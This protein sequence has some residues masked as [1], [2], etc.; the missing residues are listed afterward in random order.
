MNLNNILLWDIENISYK[1]LDEIEKKIDSQYD[2]KYIISKIQFNSVILKKLIEHNYIALSALKDADSSIINEIQKISNDGSITII[3]NDSD[4]V[5][6]IKK[7][8]KKH[9]KVKWIV[10]D[11]NKKRILMKSDLSFENL[12]FEILKNTKNISNNTKKLNNF[13]RYETNAEKA[14][15]GK[16][17]FFNSPKSKHSIK[18]QK[19]IEFY[20]NKIEKAEKRRD[21][22]KQI[23]E[24]KENK[25][26][27]ISSCEV[28]ECPNNEKKNIGKLKKAFYVNICENCFDFYK[29]KNSEKKRTAIKFQKWKEKN[30]DKIKLLK[31][32][33]GDQKN[34]IFEQKKQKIINEYQKKEYKRRL[35]TLETRKERA[36]CNICTKNGEV[37]KQFHFEEEY[38]CSKCYKLFIYENKISR[39]PEL[40]SL[41]HN[42]RYLK[43]KEDKLWIHARDGYLDYTGVSQVKLVEEVI[44]LNR[45]PNE[46]NAQ[47][48]KL[49]TESMKN[50]KKTEKT[51]KTETEDFLSKGIFDNISKEDLEKIKRN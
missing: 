50:I 44:D 26:P 7:S 25:N 32:T 19:E 24:N 5:S 21:Y 41:S 13:K 6:S 3:S 34:F 51:E 23:K 31:M 14:E 20:K 30:Q 15:K 39:N 43:F 27:I 40:K 29:N 47:I 36:K 45:L 1:R 33:T 8:L 46:I 48:D 28:C 37:Y 22:I 10:E 35:K 17:L 9:I 18:I 38:L 2:K 11:N 42:E 16:K 12:S 4:F 49:K